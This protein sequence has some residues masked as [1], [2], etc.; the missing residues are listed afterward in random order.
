MRRRAPGPF[1][2][3]SIP[4]QAAV[5]AQIDALVRVNTQA[6]LVA[7]RTVGSDV[8]AAIATRSVGDE[9]GNVVPVSGL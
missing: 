9:P 8:A 7:V 3:A 1:S 6:L 5:V 2:G 4:F